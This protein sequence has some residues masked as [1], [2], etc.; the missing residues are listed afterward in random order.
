MWRSWSAL[1]TGLLVLTIGLFWSFPL[2]LSPKTFP[3]AY[4]GL[5]LW[6]WLIFYGSGFRLKVERK[7]S[8][9]PKQPYIFIANHTST[10]DIM[11]MAILH[12]RHPLVF[13]GKAELSRIPIFG[14]IYKKICIVVDRSDIRSRTH[15]YTLAKERLALGQSI[16]LF[17]EGGI[18]DD[19][20]VTLARFKDGPF[21]LSISTHTPIAVYAI[22]GLRKMYPEKMT[23]G[24]PGTV[25]VTLED[26]IQ[27][28][29]AGLTDKK[30]LREICFSRIREALDAE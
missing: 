18:P 14:M 28:E 30:E 20:S 22:R 19:P 6:A 9:N 21:T 5:R 16:V 17:P 3:L 12:P 4:K 27:P 25:R 2:A 24:Y 26:V 10:L 29:S 8:L 7:E 15:V 1:L 13:V 23:E 11:V